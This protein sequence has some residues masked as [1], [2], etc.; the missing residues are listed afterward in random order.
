[1]QERVKIEAFWVFKELGKDLST[2]DGFKRGLR[3]K[4]EESL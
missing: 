4:W 2:V 3:G 1:M